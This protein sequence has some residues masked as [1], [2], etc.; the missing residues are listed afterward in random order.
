MGPLAALA[1]Q[2]TELTYN[3]AGDLTAVHEGSAAD[4]DPARTQAATGPR[5]GQ[6][7]VGQQRMKIADRVTVEIEFSRVVCQHLDGGLVVQ[8]HLRFLRAFS[9]RI[10]AK[11][12]QSLGGD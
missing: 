5:I 4:A 6:E 11:F 7:V 3:E 1:R 2:Q 10:F 12:Q 8:D 9:L